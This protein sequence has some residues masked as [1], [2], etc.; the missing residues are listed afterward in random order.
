MK[1]KEISSKTKMS[2][3][4]VAIRSVV[5]YDAETKI[6]TKDEEEN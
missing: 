6:L 5:T 3:Y 1:S 2:V 4:K